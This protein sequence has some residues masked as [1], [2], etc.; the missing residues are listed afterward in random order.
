MIDPLHFAAIK[1]AIRRF[2]AFSDCD[3]DE[4]KRLKDQRRSWVIGEFLLSYPEK[5]KTEAEHLYDEALK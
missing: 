3:S 5:T 2:N 4:R 1:Y